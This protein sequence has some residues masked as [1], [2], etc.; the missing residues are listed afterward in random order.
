MPRKYQ[1]GRYV[2]RANDLATDRMSVVQGPPAPEWVAV[3]YPDPHATE[4]QPPDGF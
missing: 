4:R 1:P 2:R 3:G